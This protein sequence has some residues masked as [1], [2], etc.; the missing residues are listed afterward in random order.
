M[1]LERTPQ[2]ECNFIHSNGG[3]YGDA[4][5]NK[6][7][8]NNIEKLLKV[9]G[10][11]VIPIFSLIKE[12]KSRLELFLSDITDRFFSSAILRLSE[13]I[14]LSY[15]STRFLNDDTVYK[16]LEDEGYSSFTID[17]AIIKK[18]QTKGKYLGI[19]KIIIADKS[20]IMPSGWKGIGHCKL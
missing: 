16:Y 15:L 8:F 17:I 10:I 19:A 11:C 9:D 4:L 14:S 6:F 18:Q 20:W 3:E 2:D 1:R 13:N 12:N 5:V 7:I